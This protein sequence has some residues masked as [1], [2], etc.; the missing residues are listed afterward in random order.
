MAKRKKCTRKP[1]K[2]KPECIIRAYE[3]ARDGMLASDIAKAL[4]ISIVTYKT[5]YHNRPLFR[6]GI[7]MGRQFWQR[8]DSQGPSFAKWMYS[9]L[10][11]RLRD[12]WCDITELEMKGASQKTLRNYFGGHSKRARQQLFIYAWLDS[13][14]SISRACRKIGIS[15]Q[16]FFVWCKD[17][18]FQ[19]LVDE[20][21]EIKKD[22][23]EGSL[24]RL[25]AGGD[26]TATIFANKA[27]N[28][29]RGYGEDRR[30]NLHVEGEVH[31][32]YELVS[33]EQLNLPTT[34]QKLLLQ[35]VRQAKQIESHTVEA[36]A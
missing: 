21:Q 20:V 25:V 6:M 19:S 24:I 15:R 13:N 23:F 32:K 4:G 12:I 31:H 35:H 16:T 26:T 33:M 22:F 5:W 2:W 14:F 3:F 9:R 1:Q 29:D 27:V 17:E 36:S 28:K 10:P 11:R 34:V 18:K 30:V 8:R 7:R